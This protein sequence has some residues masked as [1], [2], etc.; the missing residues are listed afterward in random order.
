MT[1]SGVHRSRTEVEAA[2]LLTASGFHAQAVSRAYYAAFY[3]AEAALLALGISRSKHSGVLSA[4]GRH[5]AR[6]GGLP[7][8][9]GRTLHLLF[10]LRNT[11]DYDDVAVSAEHA[12]EAIQDAERLVDAVEAW[13]SR[14]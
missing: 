14:R 1:P 4:F 3:T 10:D 12:L 7:S 6:D 13:L 9:V 2:R 5:L 8:E 11:V